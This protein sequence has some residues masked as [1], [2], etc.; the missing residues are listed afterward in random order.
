[1]S[2]R[3]S[4]ISG[5]DGADTITI[6]DRGTARQGV[7]VYAS[8]RGGADTI[9]ATWAGAAEADIYGGPGNDTVFT[10]LPGIR[11]ARAWGGDGDDELTGGVGDEEL[12]GGP[13]ND[14]ITGGP[15]RD[16]IWAGDY[17]G[18]L[19]S[20]DDDII[21]V[22]DG[23]TDSVSC[24]AGRDQSAADAQDTLDMDCEP[25]AP[26]SSSGASSSGSAIVTPGDDPSSHSTA[27]RQP[28]CTASL[29]ILAGSRMSARKP[30]T[31]SGH[32][33]RAGS[34]IVVTLSR[35]KRRRRVIALRR[36]LS[37]PRAGAF[38][39]TIAIRDQ[40]PG[41]YRLSVSL[42]AIRQAKKVRSARK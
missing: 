36:T 18:E 15:G 13:G 41:T 17:A 19:F 34:R 11:F 20:P 39:R 25:P 26:V 4:I 38:R 9:T 5:T 29:R 10:G 30:L 24:G 37:V 7:A 28:A 6:A 2:S 16:R 3:A 14:R 31:V 21:D 32:A 27:G 12:V 35:L 22:R 1:M 8:G 23:E 40:R 33:C 42:G